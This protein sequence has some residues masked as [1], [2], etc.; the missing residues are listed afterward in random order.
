MPR[1]RVVRTVQ[2]ERTSRVKLLEGLFDLPALKTA[3]QTVEVELPLEE[4]PW[5][6]GLI[7]GPSGCGKSTVARALWPEQ[8]CDG[9]AWSDTAALVDGFPSGMAIK[10][11]TGLLSSVG[12]SSPPAWLRPFKTLSNGEQFRATVARAL[13]ENRELV[14]ID[15]FTSVVDRTVARIGSAAVAKAI[16]SRNQGRFVAVSCHDD[17]VEWLQPD[18]VYY[19][20]TGEFRWRC[21]QRRP[22]ISLEIHR[23]PRSY[24]RMFAHHHYL[25]GELSPTADCWLGRVEGRPAV[26]VATIN[27]Q[28]PSGAFRGEHRLVC[29]PDFQGVGLGNA[30]SETVASVYSGLGWRYCSVSGH[31]AII[32]HRNRSKNWRCNRRTGINVPHLGLRKRHGGTFT[33]SLGRLTA[34]FQYVGPRMAVDLARRIRKLDLARFLELKP[35]CTPNVLARISNVGESQV[36]RW[37]AEQVKAKTVVA[38]GSGRGLDRIS[39]RL[40]NG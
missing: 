32:A 16:R 37:L 33:E 28:H 11:I 7:V 27:R 25:S 31:P 19:P 21:L 4:K 22:T 14:V 29:L 20:A 23:C 2:V 13:A 12:F 39:Y 38:H 24:W 18:W 8:M 26:F 6:I 17:I 10:E 9:H 1:A 5:L 3:Q 35:N 40:A 36:R 34:S 30:M 15:E